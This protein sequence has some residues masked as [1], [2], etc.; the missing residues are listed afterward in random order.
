MHSLQTATF[1]QPTFCD[2]CHKF[3]WGVVKQG[4][5]CVD[6]KISL[7]HQCQPIL[8]CI[9][10]VA[11]PLNMMRTTKNMHKF[12]LRIGFLRSTEQMLLNILLWSDP[13]IS[14]ICLLIFTLLCLY[15]ILLFLLPNLAVIFISIVSHPRLS[16][17][18]PQHTYLVPPKTSHQEYKLNLQFIQNLM[19]NASAAIDS[20]VIQYH[21]HLAWRNEEHTM[22]VIQFS[23]ACIPIVIIVYLF[24]PFNII[25]LIVG[26]SL[27][28]I[29]SPLKDH[30][31]EISPIIKD[32]IQPAVKAKRR[33]SNIDIR[34]DGLPGDTTATSM[35]STNHPVLS[36]PDTSSSAPATFSSQVT[37]TANL[38]IFE[39][40]RLIEGIYVATCLGNDP[41]P[42]SDIQ[43]TIPFPA[44]GDYKTPP[45]Y[46]FLNEWHIDSQWNKVDDEGWCLCDDEFNPTLPEKHVSRKRKWTRIA[47]K[48]DTRTPLLGA[49]IPT[50]MKSQG[51]LT[52]YP[53]ARSSSL[54]D[55]KMFDD[56]S[57]DEEIVEYVED[58]DINEG[59]EDQH[60]YE[61]SYENQ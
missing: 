14:I 53:P 17:M 6:C 49:V 50:I 25:C 24:F 23:I 8:P 29:N 39:N 60:I 26:W 34:S 41:P 5:E 59:A 31:H 21:E 48:K 15:P 4:R 22:K 54:H 42:Y 1:H 58:S 35:S 43:G 3:I 56:K 13:T 37:N 38:T 27:F 9:E 20:V 12:L 47:V 40:Q 2:A 51:S 46:E 30:I 61:Y 44:P 11:K 55:F 36:S 33:I 19:F 57:T 28:L 45:G 7:H 18:K 52:D 32:I 10:A 16:G